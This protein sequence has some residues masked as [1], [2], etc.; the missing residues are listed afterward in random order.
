MPEGLSPSEVGHEIA[1]HREHA[2]GPP[3]GSDDDAGRDRLISIAEAL[4]LSLVA[5][6]AAWSGYSA[7]KWGTQSSFSLARASA[8][9]TKANRADLEA[10]QIRT[11]DSVSFNAVVIAYT[12]HT[13][14]AYKIAVRRLR[15]GYRVAFDA[16]VATHPL[17]NPNAPPSPA[18]MPQYKIPQQVRSK[19]LD[20]RADAAFNNGESAG[21]TSDKYIRITVFLATVLFIVGISSHFPLRSA[22]YAM[23]GIGCVLLAVSVEQLIILPGPPA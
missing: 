4:L 6:L 12:A 23:I 10:L 3:H 2:A 8:I 18:Y 21:G 11:L 1:A 13:A 7:A 20:A 17:K 15:P 19:A 9:R 16:W 14:A 22:R 5:V